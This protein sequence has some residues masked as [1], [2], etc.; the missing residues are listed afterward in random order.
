MAFCMGLTTCYSDVDIFVHLHSF[1]RLSRRLSE[2][3]SNLHLVP[4]TR[5]NDS[6]IPLDYPCENFYVYEIFE[7]DRKIDH[8]VSIKK[9][10]CKN[11]AVF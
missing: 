7:G 4:H 5:Q 11:L 3:S 6:E 9:I 2:D 10:N 1:L 8:Q